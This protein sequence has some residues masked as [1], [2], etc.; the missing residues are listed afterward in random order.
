PL[1]ASVITPDTVPL[2]SPRLFQRRILFS[3]EYL[4]R[5]LDDATTRKA[6]ES[7]DGQAAVYARRY[8]ISQ[9][10]AK[11]ILMSAKAEGIDPELGFRLVRVESVFKTNARSPVGALGLTQLMPSTARA[12]DRSL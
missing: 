3:T 7:D 11:T 1:T 5:A 10:L 9:E 4:R 2:S 12:L 6:A 8:G